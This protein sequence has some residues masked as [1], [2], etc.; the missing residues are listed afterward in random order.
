MST[1]MF[2][3][4]ERLALAGDAYEEY[5]HGPLSFDQGY[6]DTL[7]AAYAENAAGSRAPHGR[8]PAMEPRGELAS[9]LRWLPDYITRFTGFGG[10]AFLDA[11]VDTL[12]RRMPQAD[13]DECY[14]A[15]LVL[16]PAVRELC[17]AGHR[18]LT[19]DLS[20]W[21]HAPFHLLDGIRGTEAKPFFAE[22][23]L[24]ARSLPPVYIGE[25]S[26]HCVVSIS[27]DVTQVGKGSS[28]CDF[29]FEEMPSETFGRQSRGSVY[30][31]ACATALSL[32]RYKRA[33]T[34]SCTA[35]G[36]FSEVLGYEPDGYLATAVLKGGACT[37]FHLPDE[38]FC[39]GNRLL[40]PDGPCSW[41]EV[42]P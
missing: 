38:F 24:P 28:H 27:G 29:T 15:H 12:L 32:S 36:E 14:H 16:S 20:E 39:E 4:L 5:T 3:G 11:V 31:F 25:G 9:L 8:I 21:P 41:K 23:I 6:V 13:E 40:I 42:R 2:E 37:V 18:S 17:K 35:D 30:R 7:A 1:G 19:L 33:V 26:E 34:G 22:C 10:Q